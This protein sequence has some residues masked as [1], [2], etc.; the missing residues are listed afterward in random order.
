M[1]YISEPT[2]LV[3]VGVFNGTLEESVKK[4]HPLIQ[5]ISFG[6]GNTNKYGIFENTEH[7]YL[8]II[9]Q[10]KQKILS[11]EGYNTSLSITSYNEKRNLRLAKKFRNLSGIELNIEVPEWFKQNAEVL[12]QAFEIF[13]KHPLDAMRFLSNL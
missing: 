6:L 9:A 11:P 7:P 13:E 8:F 5:P 2:T 10:Q 1:V 3:K 4:F 12:N